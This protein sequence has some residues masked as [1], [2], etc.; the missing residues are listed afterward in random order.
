MFSEFF[1]C[2]RGGGIQGFPIYSKIPFEIF[3]PIMDEDMWD[4]NK[5]TS[6]QTEQQNW[7]LLLKHQ[8]DDDRQSNLNE[9]GLFEYGGT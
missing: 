5:M 4:N 9:L 7:V 6:W 2:F 8:F 1:F 3:S